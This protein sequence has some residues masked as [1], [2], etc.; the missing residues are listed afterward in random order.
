VS[1]D[2]TVLH[3]LLLTFNYREEKNGVFTNKAVSWEVVNNFVKKEKSLPSNTYQVPGRNFYSFLNGAI[4]TDPTVKRYFK[5]IDLTLTSGGTEIL[6]Y[7]SIGQANLGITSSGEIPT[8]TNMDKGGLGLLSSKV[9]LERK[10]MTLSI[11]TL[12]SLRLGQI[13]KLLN[14]Q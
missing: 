12:D 11:S 3:D 7:V 1:D 8:Y 13:T 10:K 9:R 5:D 4:S 6:D 2:Y 14:F